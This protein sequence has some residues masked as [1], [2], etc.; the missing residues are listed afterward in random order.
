MPPAAERVRLTI[1]EA[2]CLDAVKDGLDGKT[3]IAIETKQDLE[4][5]AKALENLGRARLI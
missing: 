2:A 4:T 3:K 1:S 5:V